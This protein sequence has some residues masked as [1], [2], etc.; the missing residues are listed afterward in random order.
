MVIMTPCFYCNKNSEYVSLKPEKINNILAVVDVCKD[1]FEFAF[2][3][4]QY[5]AVAREKIRVVKGAGAIK[6]CY[7]CALLRSNYLLW[8]FSK[9][10][11]SSAKVR[12]RILQA[13]AN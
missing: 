2:D 1:H 3:C 8:A 12:F 7:G 13:W 9:W 10:S 4:A 5:L 11:S 6:D